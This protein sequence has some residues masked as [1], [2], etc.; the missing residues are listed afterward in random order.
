M[1]STRN[2]LLN[3]HSNGNNLNLSRLD[4][5]INV[6][7]NNNQSSEAEKINEEIKKLTAEVI[8]HTSNYSNAMANTITSNHSSNK[9]NESFVKG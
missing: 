7:D 1:S 9:T 3:Y 8:A 5:S 2:P 6:D 4:Q